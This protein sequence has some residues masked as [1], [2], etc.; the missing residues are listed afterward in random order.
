[1]MTEQRGMKSNHI[2]SL[3]TTKTKVAVLRENQSDNETVQRQCFR[4]NEH[5]E[6]AHVQLVGTFDGIRTVAQTIVPTN[7][8]RHVVG[9]HVKFSTTRCPDTKA[10]DAHLS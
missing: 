2:L 6:H 8:V 5:N 7:I 9:S 10:A 3:F 1:M 4:E